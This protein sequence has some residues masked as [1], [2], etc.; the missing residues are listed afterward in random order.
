MSCHSPRYKRK[1]R[2]FK[3]FSFPL[4]RRWRK[5]SHGTSQEHFGQQVESREFSESPSRLLD[6]LEKPQEDPR[7]P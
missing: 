2:L 1:K 3:P 6:G 4:P 7:F 5:D